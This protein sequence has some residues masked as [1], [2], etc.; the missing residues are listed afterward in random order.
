MACAKHRPHCQLA[1]DLDGQERIFTDSVP[2][3]K[4]SKPTGTV[5]GD[6]GERDTEF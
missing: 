3:R 1:E 6:F 5:F 2:V 4:D